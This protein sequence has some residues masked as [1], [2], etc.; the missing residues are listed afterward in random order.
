MAKCQV[1]RRKDT[2]VTSR[3]TVTESEPAQATARQLPSESSRRFRAADRGL[4]GIIASDAPLLAYLTSWAE[5]TSASTPRTSG[6][7]PI[8]GRSRLL[9]ELS[10]TACHPLVAPLSAKPIPTGKRAY[11][12]LL[13]LSGSQ[14]LR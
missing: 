10:S 14:E 4:T 5:L 2:A 11:A 3:Q 8:V 1:P 13:Q 7:Y 6:L 9:L 12:Q